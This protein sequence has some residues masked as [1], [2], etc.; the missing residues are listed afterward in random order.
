[1]G[2]P[3][4]FLMDPLERAGVRVDREQGSSACAHRRIADPSRSDTGSDTRRAAVVREEAR[5]CSVSVRVDRGS[6]WRRPGAAC[7]DGSGSRRG[8]V[9]G[10]AGASCSLRRAARTLAALGKRRPRMRAGS[11]RLPRASGRMSEVSRSDRNRAERPGE[12]RALPK[13]SSVSAA[14]EARLG[15]VEAGSSALGQARQADDA[16]PRDRVHEAVARRGRRLRVA[17]APGAGPCRRWGAVPGK[18]P[19]H[20]P[21]S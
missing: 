7:R 2:Q 1:M 21:R 19:H 14:I 6:R 17:A 11:R 9:V 15:E 8:V 5:D 3:V 12:P 18:P 13:T 16:A 10:G 4:V 20:W